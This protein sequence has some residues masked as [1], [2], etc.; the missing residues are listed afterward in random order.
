MIRVRFVNLL[1][2]QELRIK[3]EELEKQVA[4]LKSKL[5]E[6]EQLSKARGLSGIF[7][8]KQQPSSGKPQNPVEPSSS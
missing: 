5:E 6:L 8:L 3:D 4:D 7:Q 1:V 2:L